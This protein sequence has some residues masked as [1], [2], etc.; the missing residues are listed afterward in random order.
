MKFIEFCIKKPVTILMFVLVILLFGIVSLSKLKVN[1][2]PNI[3]YP[4]I[5][6]RTE[7]DDISPTEIENLIT[8][9]IEEAAGTVN[10][11]VKAICSLS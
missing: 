5:T 9:P 6:I 3:S 4:M 2:L 11:V 7:Y 10:N 8:K 1:L